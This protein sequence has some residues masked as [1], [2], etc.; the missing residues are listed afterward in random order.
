MAM[1]AENAFLLLMGALLA[2]RPFFPVSGN[3]MLTM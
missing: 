2:L 1:A 3:A